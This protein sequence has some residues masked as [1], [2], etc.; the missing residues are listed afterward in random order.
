MTKTD[1]KT[2]AAEAER[3]RALQ[4]DTD[5]LAGSGL[6]EESPVPER[7]VVTDLEPLRGLPK[8]GVFQRS[9]TDPDVAV[10]TTDDR[11]FR[12][13]HEL[14]A[15]TGEPTGKSSWVEITELRGATE[16][17]HEDALD[18]TEG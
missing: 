5:T 8:G 4:H 12:C 11:R 7:F 14:D 16:I 2:E 10:S 13:V 9:L 17:V 1:E 3:Q 18:K 15:E 6:L